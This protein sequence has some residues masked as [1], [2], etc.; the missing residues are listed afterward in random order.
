[1][2]DKDLRKNSEG[3]PDPTAYEAIKRL[4]AEEQ[5]VNHLLKI[6]FSVCKLAGFRVEGRIV[7]EDLETG[8]IWR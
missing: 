4:E 8:K 7:L 1:M 2:S 3:Y 5:K 6:I